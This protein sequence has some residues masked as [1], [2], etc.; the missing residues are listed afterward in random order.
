M[1]ARRALRERGRR[2]AVRL[3]VPRPRRAGISGA[4]AGAIDRGAHGRLRRRAAVVRWRRTDASPP[5]D[6]S[7]ESSTRSNEPSLRSCPLFDCAH[8]TQLA[9]TRIDF[10]AA[11]L[12]LRLR[13]NADAIRD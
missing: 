12:P 10:R 2:T 13:T 7:G 5:A 8:D 4:L 6:W 11:R 9:I 3:Q 1:G